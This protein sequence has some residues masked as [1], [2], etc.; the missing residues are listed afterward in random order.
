MLIEFQILP[1]DPRRLVS[2]NPSI[3][4]FNLNLNLLV[5]FEFTGKFIGRPDS[6]AFLRERQENE[7]TFVIST[8]RFLRL[9][10]VCSLDMNGTA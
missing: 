9:L 5:S 7:R 6:N 3:D 2:F 4:K 1:M 8:P 10:S